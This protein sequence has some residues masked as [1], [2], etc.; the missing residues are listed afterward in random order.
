VVVEQRVSYAI[1]RLEP[2]VDPQTF[3]FDS[4]SSRLI[5]SQIEST[6]SHSCLPSMFRQPLNYENSQSTQT[7]GFFTSA[8][9]AGVGFVPSTSPMAVI[10]CMSSNQKASGDWDPCHTSYVDLFIA[11][12]PAVSFNLRMPGRL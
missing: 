6:R 10:F 12:L 2:H 9:V 1:N 4:N 8:A 5:V 3:D 7:D 11:D